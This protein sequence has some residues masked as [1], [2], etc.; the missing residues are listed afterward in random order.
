MTRLLIAVLAA[1]LLVQAT[2]ALGQDSDDRSNARMVQLQERVDE[3]YE[4][5]RYE[6]AYVIY[7]DELAAVGDKY[8][9]YMVGYMTLQGKGVTSDPALASAWYRLA[10]DRG[11]PEFV[12]VRDLLLKDLDAAQMARSDS[13][14]RELRRRYSDVAILLR[15]I[16]RDYARLAQATGSRLAPGGGSLSIVDTR[17]SAAGEDYYVQV[18]KQL[19]MHLTKLAKLTAID[20]FET[21]PDKTNADEVR[22]HLAEY[23][24]DGSG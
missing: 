4:R 6:R 11:T 2:T 15:L 14:Y 17:S 13:A 12:Y 10:A 19:E 8:A 21:D 7:R 5:G 24:D 16:E 23:L 18:R 20:G 9:Q 1:A 3:L 22:E